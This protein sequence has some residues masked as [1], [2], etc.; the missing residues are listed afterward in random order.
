MK[1]NEII[2]KAQEQAGEY[3]T[4]YKHDITFDS[5]RNIC[6][7]IWNRARNL[8][9][10]FSEWHMEM[11]TVIGGPNYRYW[12]D[13]I[14]DFQQEKMNQGKYCVCDGHRYCA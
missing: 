13:Q 4:G 14:M 12:M 2:K 11:R 10:N 1:N 3:V 7:M 6:E 9:F 8:A 5:L